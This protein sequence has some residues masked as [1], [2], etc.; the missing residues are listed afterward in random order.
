MP[1]NYSA[2]Y[3]VA[4]FITSHGFGHAA[5]SVAIM[6]ALS[7]LGITVHFDIYSDIPEW[8][9]ID[10]FSGSYTYH[11]CLTDIGLIQ[12]NPLH[13]DIEFTLNALGNFLPFKESLIDNYAKELIESN[14][15]LII[16]DISPLG[17]EISAQTNI[18][19][20][21]VENFTWDWIYEKYVHNDYQFKFYINYLKNVFAKADYH[22][23]AEPVCYL[24]KSLQ[25]VNPI[26]RKPRISSA[27][28]RH[29]LKI[30]E[31]KNVILIT[32]RGIQE[33]YTFIDQLSLFPDIFFII[34]GGGEMVVK[35]KNFVLLPH[36]SEYYHPDL[37]NTA[38]TVISKI[39]Y[40]TLAETFYSGS[41]LGYI[42]RLEFRESDQLIPYIK[43]NFN[44]HSITESD[45]YSGS[46]TTKINTLVTFP[47]L[48]RDMPNGAEQIASLI[49]NILGSRN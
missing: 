37:I 24:Q 5:R 32:I 26:S 18:P 41:S 23:Q 25:Q 35:S 7:R 42:P 45:F 12:I 6:E 28:I 15:D 1:D 31:N 19:S 21:L 3:N 48:I 17:I 49:V 40:S 44:G 34:P 14:C 36:K 13:A 20:L 22:I 47:R 2:T 33:A 38:D 16:S 27:E 30:P 39:G 46:W 4:Y 9:I 8:F 11:N 43:E 10:S 29:E